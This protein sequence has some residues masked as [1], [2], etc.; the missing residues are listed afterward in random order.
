[1]Q[2]YTGTSQQF[3]EDATHDRIAE[4]LNS[5]F[6][7]HFGHNVARNEFRAWENSLWR[8]GI[9]LQDADLLDNGII[10][11]YKLGLTSRRL[12]CMVTGTD[13]TLRPSAVIVELKQ[14][15]DAQV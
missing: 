5:A 3:I 1:M 6:A 13:I 10:L 4:K 7:C 9:V 8:M 14:W 15:E 11:E 12:D 2:L